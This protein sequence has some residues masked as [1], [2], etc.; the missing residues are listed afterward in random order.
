LLACGDDELAN[1]GD[2]GAV[3][4]DGSVDGDGGGAA[5]T[6]APGTD[7]A[8]S[9]NE[10]D[11]AMPSGS[12]SSF[13][14]ERDSTFA[15]KGLTTSGTFL[16]ARRI[17]DSDDLLI[18]TQVPTSSSV[19]RVCK[20]SFDG[21]LDTSY[22]TAGCVELMGYDTNR[23]S[24]TESFDVDSEGRI[25]FLRAV[26]ATPG[27]FL[28]NAFEISRFDDG[29]ALDTTFGNAGLVTIPVNALT[30]GTGTY[31]N[32]GAWTLKIAS[33]GA[34]FVGGYVQGTMGDGPMGLPA[35]K[36]IL[37]KLDAAGAVVKSF[38]STG[39]VLFDSGTNGALQ[40]ILEQNDGTIFI[41]GRH[42]PDGASRP[43]RVA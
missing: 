19:L 37:L 12:A 1:V 22:G 30:G 35:R 4:A 40:H 11:A 3:L 36:W 20:A 32:C 10:N 21:Q 23:G 14:G 38:N 7:A 13:T 29:G 26:S 5:G 8:I 41:V 6:S 43:V 39:Y 42:F 15:R 28:V 18:F 31:N 24:D 16:A 2:G 9:G 25:Y 33:D 27:V 34:L 17:G